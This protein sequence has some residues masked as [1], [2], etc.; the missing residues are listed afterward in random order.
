MIKPTS[1]KVFGQKYKIKYDY[2]SEE[3]HGITD[4]DTNTI[5]IASGLPE[6]KLLRVLMHEIT[7]AIINGTPLCN[8]KR[9]I[10]EEVCDIVGFHFI[11]M[12]KDNPALLE[13]VT[14]E[15]EE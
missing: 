9:F 6:D 5:S 15:I 13:W 11:D 14:K 2:V 8:R 7:H 10:E 4:F 12:L 1:V 3:N